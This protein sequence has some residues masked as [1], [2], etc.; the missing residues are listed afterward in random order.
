MRS[1]W[2]ACLVSCATATSGAPAA[3]ELDPE[4]PRRL[5]VAALA[6]G[7]TD[8]VWQLL[9]EGPRAALGHREALGRWLVRYG[10][11]WLVQLA[12]DGQAPALE[13]R[14]DGVV[15]RATESGWGVVS[16]PGLPAP[17]D[18]LSVVGRLARTA[19]ALASDAVLAPDLRQ[20]WQHLGAARRAL[21]PTEPA[22][23]PVSLVDAG[24]GEV[25]LARDNGRWEARVFRVDRP[26]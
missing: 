6:A 23:T 7:D 17:G 2:L 25:V 26:K 9:D 14:V 5:L 24:S 21:P 19:E 22:E 3:P 16:G 11:E 13:W 12:A 18:Y 20:R 4:A 15:L 8:G 10:A 1:A